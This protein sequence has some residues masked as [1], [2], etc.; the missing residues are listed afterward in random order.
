MSTAEHSTRRR[1]GTR[2]AGVAA[3]LVA[4]VLI[5][6]LPQ[7]LYCN[8]LYIE[9]I[10][11][12][13]SFALQA[14]V[15]AKTLAVFALGWLLLFI[16][17]FLLGARP[18]PGQPLH[19]R[20][21]LVIPLLCLL[22]AG[23]VGVRLWSEPAPGPRPLDCRG[24]VPH[25][26]PGA[27]IDAGP[28]PFEPAFFARFNGLG[29]RGPERDPSR[30]IILA[31]GDSFIYGTGVDDDFTIPARLERL[32]PE[33][34]VLNAGLEGDNLP[35]ALQR[36]LGWVMLLS[37]RAV[38]IGIYSNDG[39]H[40]SATAICELPPCCRRSELPWAEIDALESMA[41]FEG[42]QDPTWLRAEIEKRWRPLD[43][44]L[45]QRN[46]PLVFYVFRDPPAELDVDW[47][48]ARRSQS[49]T[50]H[51]GCTGEANYFDQSASHPNPTGTACMAAEIAAALK[52]LIEP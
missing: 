41:R 15:S 44:W 9:I 13:P 43:E 52:P 45:A 33:F 7:S 3:V 24:P 6:E 47:L 49:V 12:G 29:M 1:I 31:V 10:E 8:L 5:A 23:L 4:A 21:A 22:P 17:A 30:P 32:M 38:V 36:A 39:N 50:L 18:G 40:G 11:L 14:A 28:S 35:G 19:R 51:G 46:I 27:S 42:T 2:I 26:L 34:Q 48:T 20:L 37:V 25:R 16:G